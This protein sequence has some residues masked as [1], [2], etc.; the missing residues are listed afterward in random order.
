MKEALALIGVI[1]L[2]ASLWF[3]Q[4]HS[5]KK[6]IDSQDEVIKSLQETVQSKEDNII[7]SDALLDSKN[8]AIKS[9]GD[10]IESKDDAVAKL[11]SV[12]RT[13][14][15]TIESLRDGVQ[16]K[17][18]II[19]KDE[20]IISS[21]Q[22]QIARYQDQ[23]AQLSD[24]EDLSVN[25]NAQRIYPR[26]NGFDAQDLGSGFNAYQIFG[27]VRNPLNAAIPHKI[28]NQTPWKFGGGN[29]GIAANGCG[30]Y[31]AGATNRDSDGT[32]STSGQAGYLQFKGSSISQTLLLPAGSYAVSFDY[33]GRRDYIPANQIT[34]SIDDTVLF[35][36][37]PSDF[38]SFKRVISRPILLTMSGKHELTFRGLGAEGDPSGDHTTFIDNIS[39]VVSSTKPKLNTD[40]ADPEVE[41]Q[42]HSSDAPITFDSL[43]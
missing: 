11:N 32:T 6:I 24:R 4:E 38:N 10:S 26:D 42:N 40:G 37:T 8:T 34:V 3:L 43:K 31:L 16:S 19:T 36:G 35:K 28:P 13:K 29:S 7:K 23:I 5:D 25:D 22:N 21:D 27:P 14:D 41:H 1:A 30:F 12:L 9:L 33:A 15:E 20:G 18:D 39:L 17:E 2:A